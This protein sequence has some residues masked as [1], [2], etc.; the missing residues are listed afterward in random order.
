MSLLA[1]IVN[2]RQILSELTTT[3]RLLFSAKLRLKFFKVNFKN[4]DDWEKFATIKF[5]QNIMEN[6]LYNQKKCR[7]EVIPP[8]KYYPKTVELGKNIL[9]IELK[10][11]QDIKKLPRAMDPL[12][13]M[14]SLRRAAKE[15]ICD[16]KKTLK[17]E[18]PYLKKRADNMFAFKT[19]IPENGCDE[20]TAEN[21]L[22]EVKKYEEHVLW[23]IQKMKEVVR[24]IKGVREA[25]ACI[26][27]FEKEMEEE[28]FLK[29]KRK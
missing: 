5:L 11:P 6:R 4:K 25:N 24:E 9:S 17:D 7:L 1:V 19:I 29:K 18:G 23:K 15:D 16:F 20:G 14:K 22:Q 27:E 8:S 12:S 10:S 21:L 2:L 28:A 26:M 3:K 13:F